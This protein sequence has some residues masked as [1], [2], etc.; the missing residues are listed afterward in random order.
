MNATMFISQES[1]DVKNSLGAERR[2]L[3]ISKK[4]IQSNVAVPKDYKRALELWKSQKI[5]TFMKCDQLI[6]E[7]PLGPASGDEDYYE[8]YYEDYYKQL[9]VDIAMRPVNLIPQFRELCWDMDLSM[10]PI[11]LL[12]GK[13]DIDLVLMGFELAGQNAA[14]ITLLDKSKVFGNT[15]NDKYGQVF[16][17]M[18]LSQPAPY[19][20]KEFKF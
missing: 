6:I 12:G 16:Y 11:A 9:G 1:Y 15:P 18:L 8:G 5:Y 2:E 17:S 4:Q 3:E 14:D 19:D 7:L 20:F 13:E 10:P